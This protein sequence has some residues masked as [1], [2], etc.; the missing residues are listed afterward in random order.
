[1]APQ[2]TKIKRIKITRIF[3]RILLGLLFIATVIILMI[4]LV[5]TP[6]NDRDWAVDQ[7]TLPYAV[8]E[9]DNVTVKD[10]RNFSYSSRDE[11]TPN[12][13]DKTFDLNTIKSVDYIVEPL[14][15]VAAAHTFLSFGFDNGDYLGISI[16]IRKEKGEEFSPFLALLDEYEIMY[17]VVDERDTIQLRAIHR[18]NPVYLYPAEVTPDKIRPLFVDMLMR[19]NR[20]KEKP[21]F[22]NTLTNTC[23]TNIA[24]HINKL[25]PGRVP[26]DLRIL[27]P[28]DSDEL[29]YELGLID[30]TQPFEEVRKQHL[31]NE[32]VKEYANDSD[33][34]LKI[35]EAQK[36]ALINSG[37]S[38]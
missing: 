36:R 19:V 23:A 13:Y 35:R 4:L 30:N 21:E 10:V 32:Y 16:E 14:A 25:S 5:R 33:F 12:Y 37:S 3:L 20:L 38:R 34:S 29:A 15:S 31:I 18:D 1:M 27:L 22:Y 28:L 11:Y 8:F 9:G 17:V 7:Q 24:Y 2:E 26:W 6:S